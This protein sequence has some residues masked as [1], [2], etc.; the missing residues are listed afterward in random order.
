MNVKT[1][2]AQTM[3]MARFEIT[4]GATYNG[5][6][7]VKASLAS[8]KNNGGL[9]QLIFDIADDSRC[10]YEQIAVHVT[11]PHIKACQNDTKTDRGVELMARRIM[12][13]YLSSS[14]VYN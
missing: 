13:E 12:D 1:V 8:A 6:Q 3:D 9:Y 7:V 5:E 10:I 11:L 4:T 14:Y 2:A